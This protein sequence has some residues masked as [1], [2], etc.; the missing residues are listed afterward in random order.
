MKRIALFFLMMLFCGSLFGQASAEGISVLSR[1]SGSAYHGHNLYTV[2]AGGTVS[3]AVV[4][5]TP[6]L[7]YS[8][9]RYYYDADGEYHGEAL[10][11]YV[12]SEYGSVLTDGPLER[13][14]YYCCSGH[15]ESEGSSCEFLVQ[16]QNYFHSTRSFC[17]LYSGVY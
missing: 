8:W 13:A 10:S 17:A 5:E 7:I 1:D 16:I 2:D 15:N 4:S 3:L 11:N 12:T 9:S 14:Y 6:N